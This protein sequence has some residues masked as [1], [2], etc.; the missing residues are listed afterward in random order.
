MNLRILM[1]SL[2]FLLAACTDGGQQNSPRAGG[3]PGGQGRGSSQ[4]GPA[5]EQAISVQAFRAERRPVSSHLVANTTLDSIRKVNVFSKV[6]AVVIRMPVE[7]G[8]VVSAGQLLAQLDE[9]EIRNEYQQAEIAVD[10]ARLALEQAEVRA[11]LSAS[12]YQRAHSLYEENLTSKQEFDQAALASRTDELAMQSAQQQLAAVRARLEAASIQLEYTRIT[13]PIEGVVTSRLIEV[14]DQLSVS[15]QVFTVEE[16]PPLWARIQLPEKTLTQLRPGQPARISVETFPGERFPARIK[17]IS[18][19][20]DAASGTVKVTLEVDHSR[21]KL[22][23]G[24]FGTVYIT[25]DTRPDAVVVPR[26]AVIRDRDRHVVYVVDADNTVSRREVELGFSQDEWVEVVSGVNQSEVVVTVGYES[27]NEGYAV[28][29]LGW[30]GVESGTPDVVAPSPPTQQPK[31]AR[32]APSPEGRAPGRGGR[33]PSELM[34]NPE[35]RAAYE[36]RLKEDPE[37]ATDPEKRREF[38]REMFSR[39]RQ[40]GRQ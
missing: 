1:S 30:D 32:R 9:S 4:A 23:P 37:L 25:T 3:G 6:N 8:S 15:Q 34:Q 5:V 24:M 14:G 16:F 33:T 28:N 35:I 17:M 21:Q 29:I 12:E 2:V 40:N 19:T 18:P 7:E 20:I 26:K 27:L 13:S 38:F 11:R 22:R 36:A 10:E 31:Q 39:M